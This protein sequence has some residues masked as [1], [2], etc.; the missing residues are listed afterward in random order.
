MWRYLGLE[1]E[2]TADTM[3]WT[4][5]RKVSFSRLAGGLLD[6]VGFEMIG[7]A[8][9]QSSVILSIRGVLG[10]GR[11]SRRRVAAIVPHV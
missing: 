4:I 2:A 5:P 7:E 3:D 6:P 10:L 8:S 9:V 11:P 1:V